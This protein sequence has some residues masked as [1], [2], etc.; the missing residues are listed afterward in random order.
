MFKSSGT[1]AA[2]TVINVRMSAGFLTN[3]SA[4]G[5]CRGIDLFEQLPIYLTLFYIHTH[6]ITLD[7][8]E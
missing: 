2:W 4:T 3:D 8:P 5:P 7:N 1:R 6:K